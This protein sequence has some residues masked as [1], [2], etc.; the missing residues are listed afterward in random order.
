VK[1]IEPMTASNAMFE[2]DQIG[3][4]VGGV[5]GDVSNPVD[6]DRLYAPVKEQKGRIDIR[7]RRRWRISSIGP[8]HTLT[9]RSGSM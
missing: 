3:K 1:A 7:K 6:L 8:K 9:K 4:N 5:Q 2:L